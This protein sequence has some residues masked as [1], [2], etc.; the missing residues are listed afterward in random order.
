MNPIPLITAAGQMI[1]NH[2]E[3]RAL[4]DYKYN[5][6]K[7]AQEDQRLYDSPRA[8]MERLKAAGLNPDLMYQGLGSSAS[9]PSIESDNVNGS[10]LSSA[11]S[12]TI[13]ASMRAEQLELN[14]ASTESQINLNEALAEK[15]EAEAGTAGSRSKYLER[16]TQAQ[17]ILDALRI[18]N[19]DL[20]V[21]HVAESISRVDK[22]ASEIGLNSAY[23][24]W[25]NSKT[26]YQDLENSHFDEEFMRKMGLLKA[27]TSA[28]YASASESK[29][30]ADLYGKQSQLT[31]YEIKKANEAVKHIADKCRY[32]M[33]ILANQA[34]YSV[35]Q[36]KSAKEDILKKCYD[37]A[38][39]HSWIEQD[40]DGNYKMTKYGER[41][42]G[43]QM[44]SEAIDFL[45]GSVGQF[46][47]HH[48]F[49]NLTPP[50]NFTTS[51]F[52]GDAVL[53]GGSITSFGN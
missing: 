37:T 15:A 5:L 44:V 23:K 20:N 13:D 25:I 16:L 26:F 49:K 43:V 33:A 39:Y 3:S 47:T 34:E 46:Y 10:Q 30:H 8:Q 41:A 45:L 32:E 21:Q 7:Q 40:K 29:A 50:Q 53:T 19:T 17:D 28:A 42:L 6:Q 4:M 1:Y 9:M 22:I 31:D 18:S 38:R 52:D 36:V 14:K 48:S 2:E 11:G 51:H 35:I 24:E 12:A 27:Q